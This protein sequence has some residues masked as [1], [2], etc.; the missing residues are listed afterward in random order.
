MIAWLCRDNYTNLFNL[1][2]SEFI[3][4]LRDILICRQGNTIYRK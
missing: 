4:L 2:R 1:L 3:A